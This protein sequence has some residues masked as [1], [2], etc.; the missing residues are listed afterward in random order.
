MLCPVFS[1]LQTGWCSLSPACR[2][3]LSILGEM[4][5]RWMVVTSFEYYH[6]ALRR[7]RTPP[8]GLPLQ[9]GCQCC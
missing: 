6:L 3:S 1:G 4:L 9:V 2:I 5:S 7:A 8:C